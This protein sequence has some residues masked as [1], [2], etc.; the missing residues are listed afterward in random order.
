MKDSGYGKGYQYAHDFK[1]A[2]T[3]QQYLPDKIKDKRYYFP[4]ERG[5]E[6]ELKQRLEKIS[7]SKKALKNKK[8]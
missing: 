8:G 7:S 2:I 4:T 1:D 5:F 6:K 3:E